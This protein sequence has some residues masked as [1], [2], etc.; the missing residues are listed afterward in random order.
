[1][2]RSFLA[3]SLIA[4][5]AALAA[6]P[7]RPIAPDEVPASLAPAVARGE[8]AADALRDQFLKRVT[9]MLAQGGPMAAMSVCPT[10]APR[11]AKHV[12]EVHHV[13]IGRTSFRLRNPANAPRAWAASYVAA[14]AGK[15]PDELKPAVF[16]L[17]DRVGVLRPIVATP[18]CKSCHGPAEALDPQ[19]K[20]EIARRYPRDQAT[21]FATGDLRGFIWVEVGKN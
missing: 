4:A 5:S 13:E 15:K 16:D 7:S 3:L 17:G 14:G 21:G 6:E 18:A 12:G 19:A 1:M 8:T 20:A 9:A 11:I 2:S 10:E